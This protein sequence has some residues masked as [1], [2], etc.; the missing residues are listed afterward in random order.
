LI[1]SKES[2]RISVLNDRKPDDGVK[3]FSLRLAT[4][5]YTRVVIH[6]QLPYH[7]QALLG[8]IEY[9]AIKANIYDIY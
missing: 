8:I 5:T 6:L 7:L 2:I 3:K 1:K 4:V 9:T